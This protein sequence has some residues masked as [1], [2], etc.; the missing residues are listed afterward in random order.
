MHYR[1]WKCWQYLNV[2]LK[3]KGEAEEKWEATEGNEFHS[4]KFLH[5]DCLNLVRWKADETNFPRLQVLVVS[6]CYKLEEI[7][8]DIGDI[9]TLQKIYV[10]Q[11]GASVMASAKQIQ[12]VQQEEYDNYDLKVVIH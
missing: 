12:K 11:C 9:P 7:T 2:C 1:I 8:C 10:V 6:N 5:L 4:L 3:E